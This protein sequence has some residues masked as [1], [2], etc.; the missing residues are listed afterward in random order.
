MKENLWR[1]FGVESTTRV[2]LREVIDSLRFG[3]CG[4]PLQSE[5][6]SQSV[7]EWW[8]SL[9]VKRFRNA[10]AVLLIERVWD[11]HIKIVENPTSFPCLQLRFGQDG[12]SWLDSKKLLYDNLDS[13]A[14]ARELGNT[15]EAVQDH[16]VTQFVAQKTPLVISDDPEFDRIYWDLFGSIT[17]HGLRQGCF[18]R[19]VPEP[20]DSRVAYLVRGIRVIKVVFDL[21]N[22]ITKKTRESLPLSPKQ[23]RNAVLLNMRTLIVESYLPTLSVFEAFGRVTT[24]FIS[25]ESRPEAYLSNEDPNNYKLYPKLDML[26]SVMSPLRGTQLPPETHCP[27]FSGYKNMPLPRALETTLL[28]QL[29]LWFYPKYS[30]DIEQYAKN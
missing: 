10:M 7:M 25:Y 2:N 1:K 3:R 18:S 9:E 4:L 19:K 29:D 6:P 30:Q 21:P 14:V 5:G 12:V 11:N 27:F 28:R 15:N 23:H 16:L 8:N 22:L 13:F 24:D 26:S 20:V 17:L